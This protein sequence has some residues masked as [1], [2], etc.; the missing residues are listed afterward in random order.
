MPLMS[1]FSSTWLNG[2][3]PMSCMRMAASTAS[4]SLSKMKFPFCNNV[5][6]ASLIRWNAPME[7]WK[8]VCLA[9]G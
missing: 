5:V 3:W 9:P 4:A 7:C 8:R 2:P 6:I 1:V